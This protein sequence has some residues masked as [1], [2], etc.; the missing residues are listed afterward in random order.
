MNEVDVDLE[1][2]TRWAADDRPAPL[3]VPCAAR[4]ST[5]FVHLDGP[6]RCFVRGPRPQLA[7][8]WGLRPAS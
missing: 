8:A 3:V 2:L 4:P 5:A 1:V 6:C 7:P